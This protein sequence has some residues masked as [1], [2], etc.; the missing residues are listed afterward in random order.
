MPEASDWRWRLAQAL[1]LRWWKRYLRPQA[2]EHY[3]EQKRQYWLRLLHTAGLQPVSGQRALDAGCGPAGIFMVLDGLQVD[4]VDP[5]L[6]RYSA[7]LRHFVPETYLW[8]AFHAEPF[9]AWQPKAAY[10]WVFCMNAL[11]HF[12][13]MGA[14]L[15]NLYRALAPQGVLLLTV[16]AH[17]YGGLKRLFQWIP[18]DMLHPHQYSCEDYVRM[19]EEAGIRVTG[20]QK[21][22]TGRIFEYVAIIG[23][24]KG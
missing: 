9:E 7:A 3:L 22:K 2:P 19:L 1:E 10:D 16:D 12:R 20:V 13:D 8:V 21:L 14:S 5:L 11:N 24:K 6:H 18:G 17:R 4:A 15:D 23:K